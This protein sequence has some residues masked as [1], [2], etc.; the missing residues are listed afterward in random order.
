MDRCAK[1]VES[2]RRNQ[3]QFHRRMRRKCIN[4]CA[5]QQKKGDPLDPVL[6]PVER[7]GITMAAL[8]KLESI[9]KQSKAPSG[10]N[11]A[12]GALQE[13]HASSSGVS[14][15]LSQGLSGVNP[16]PSAQLPFSI[17]AEERDHAVAADVPPPW[18]TFHSQAAQSK[19]NQ[20]IARCVVS[21]A[22]VETDWSAVRLPQKPGSVKKQPLPFPVYADPANHQPSAH[23]MAGVTGVSSGQGQRLVKKE[24]KWGWRVRVRPR[25]PFAFKRALF[26]QGP[27]QEDE[28]SFEEYRAQFYAVKPRGEL[29]TPSK[30]NNSDLMDCE[31]SQ[32]SV[33]TVETVQGLKTPVVP[34]SARRKL[35]FSSV[36][37]LAKGMKELSLANSPNDDLTVNTRGVLNEMS[38]LF[39]R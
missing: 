10:T 23:A 21:P 1:P 18:G 6:S 15:Q 17:C 20:R 5:E 29:E 11:R 25:Q 4:L 8:R 14:F 39:G 12:F 31:S 3:H 19:E 13:V 7:N 26:L 22:E 38:D 9:A 33:E 30:K 16:L 2:I 32:M 37:P 35:D 28:L 34:N 24:A 27:Q 36:T